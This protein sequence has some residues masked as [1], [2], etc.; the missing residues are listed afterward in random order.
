M[1]NKRHVYEIFEAMS[2]EQ[3]KDILRAELENEDTDVDLIKRVNAV[4]S[5][6]AECQTSCDVD[7]A[8][9][10][11]K[12]NHAANE[13]IYDPEYTAKK[14]Q[15]DKKEKRRSVK[16]ISKGALTAAI[17]AALLVG[18]AITAC[19]KEYGLW[20]AV[21]NWTAENFSF[22]S[23]GTAPAVSIDTVNQIP[24]Q[25]SELQTAMEE[26]GLT[27]GLLPS[28]LPDGYEMAEIQCEGT[29][30]STDFY[31]LLESDEGSIVLEYNVYQSG[32]FSRLY[33]KDGEDPESYTVGGIT[34]Y[35]MTNF[36]TYYAVWLKDNAE[37]SISGVPSKAELCKIIDSIY[38]K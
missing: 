6:R 24:E 7:G 20:T 11:F 16:V 35:I 34:H 30:I 10:D 38:G 22:V 27:G 17:V 36:G 12:N 37:C 26:Y 9:D 33:D 19:A 3:L 8:W 25:L 4:L 31:C 28:Y 29:G 18:S 2:T 5:H 21:A 15:T 13:P 14:P 23:T 1:S 32:E